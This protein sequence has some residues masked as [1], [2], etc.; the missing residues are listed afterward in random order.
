MQELVVLAREPYV[1]V[2]L[3]Y[4]SVRLRI[5]R[6]R[7]ARRDLADPATAAA[8]Q[9]GAED[10]EQQPKGDQEPENLHVSIVQDAW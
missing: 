5:R 10:A 9:V 4:E 6:V 2:L 1:L 8:Q 7:R 3:T